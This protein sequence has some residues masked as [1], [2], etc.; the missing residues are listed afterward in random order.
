MTINHTQIAVHF[1]TAFITASASLIRTF[2]V[3][4]AP[5]EHLGELGT[6]GEIYEIR[7]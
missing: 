4:R 6:L 1:S 5:R 2:R 3:A 7:R